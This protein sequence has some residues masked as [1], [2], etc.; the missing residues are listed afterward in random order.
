LTVPSGGTLL[1]TLAAQKIF[2]PS[3]CGG[4]GSCGVCKVKVVNGGGAIL[5]TEL[6]HITR[7]EAREAYR[8]ACQ[9]KL[10]SNVRIEV[11]PEIFHIKSWTCKVRSNRNVATF[12]KELVLD[13]PPRETIPFR[14]GGYIQITCPPHCVHFKDFDVEE[15]YR[16]EWERAGLWR[17]SSTCSEE[18]TRAYSMANYPEEKDAIMLNVRIA[19]PPPRAPEETPPG[20]M[21]SYLF[22]LKPGDDVTVSGPFGEFYAK[23]TH[24]EMVFIGGGAGMAPMRSHI[25][26][27]FYR[28]K[29]SRK[30]SFWYGARSL[31]EAFY[32]D[33]FDK[34]QAEHP[35]FRW[36][37]ALSEPLPEDKWTGLRG[38]IHQVL[39]DDYLKAH[40]APEDV[41]Y[42]IC[43]PPLMLT[44]VLNMLADLGV[45]KDNIRFDDFGL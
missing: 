1:S 16:A 34:I 13:L 23:D 6:G 33:L 38:F 7:G 14:A 11:A 24:A 31:C 26:D 8:L 36:H 40:P 35:N 19:S 21:S 30:V 41:E 2:I 29:T 18:V 39:H 44:A 22:N 27:Q 12:I 9:V 15:Q 28:L 45:E 42:Y 32:I 4:K 17:L 43:G 5:P 10:K 20:I 37:L 25:L 3:A